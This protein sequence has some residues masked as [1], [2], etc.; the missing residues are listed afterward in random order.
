MPTSPLTVKT[1]KFALDKKEY[2]RIAMRQT[3]EQQKMW[4]LVP[5]GL[6]LINAILGVTGVY[7]NIWVYIVV[8]LGA[9]LYVG[10]WWVQF[11]GVTQLEQYKQ[12]F[13]KYLY[14]I[15]SRQILVKTNPKE[16]GVMP[17]DQI[18]SAYKHKEAYV[19][20]MARGQFLHFP[21]S[22][23]NSEHDLR[24]FERILKQKN[25]LAEAKA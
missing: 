18:K 24:L 7:P 23:F 9:A 6:L 20:V 12:L 5:L 14:E 19:L 21:N 17:W 10:F 8:I 3:W 11:T 22:V 2:V 15:D 16:G 13:D 25:L 1:K 4:T